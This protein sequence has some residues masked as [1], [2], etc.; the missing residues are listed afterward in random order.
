MR[1]RASPAPTVAE[2]AMADFQRGLEKM[3]QRAMA[4]GMS[5]PTLD[6]ITDFQRAAFGQAVRFEIDVC[7]PLPVL[8][9]EL[10]SIR[11]ELTN[12]LVMLEQN[13][14]GNTRR[15]MVHSALS[16]MRIGLKHERRERKLRER[17]QPIQTE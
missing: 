4:L 11:A 2:E 8:K 12:C 13:A 10:N 7:Q 1:E 9:R 5:D 6:E 16:M 14:S 15:R 17:G 3:S